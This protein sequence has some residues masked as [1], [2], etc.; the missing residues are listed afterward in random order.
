[1]KI[2]DEV[3]IDMNPESS[4]YGKHLSEES[5]DYEGDV[6]LAGGGK[7]DI[8]VKRGRGRFR[9]GLMALGRGGRFPGSIE[10]FGG[11]GMPGVY[12]SPQGKPTPWTQSP[13]TKKQ[14]EGT[15]SFDAYKGSSG[16]IGDVGGAVT[17]IVESIT[18][19]LFGFNLFPK[20][21]DSSQ[22]YAAEDAIDQDFG[23]Y[24]A[25]YI[26]K[27]VRTP[28][29]QFR[30]FGFSEGTGAFQSAADLGLPEELLS[31]APGTTMPGIDSPL[32][33][34][35]LIAKGNVPQLTSMQ[36]A[37][38][39]AI[40]DE[41]KEQI[42]LDEQLVDLKEAKNIALTEQ[43][44]LRTS[45][46]RGLATDAE[47]REAN[48]AA[49]GLYESGPAARRAMGE[50]YGDKVSLSDISGK[51]QEIEKGF[52]MQ[53]EGIE[54]EKSDVADVLTE[55]RRDFG[56]EV[57]QMLQGSTDQINTLLT[58]LKA[59]PEAH[60]A[61]GGLLASQ[62]DPISGEG[63]GQGGDIPAYGDLVGA[64]ASNLKTG[65]PT[66]GGMFT[67]EEIQLPTGST[68]SLYSQARADVDAANAF[69]N[70]MGS[71][72]FSDPFAFSTNIEGSED[73]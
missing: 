42:R 72:G 7:G 6:A 56:E 15:E 33:G 2:Y 17:D 54:G 69:A 59:I 36:S 3:T 30:G 25:D 52:Q 13:I 63:W 16:L 48:L 40:D 19:D 32:G 26:D 58:G 29:E 21:W 20:S 39:R 65:G 43:D 12:E 53:K 44:K 35:P 5:Y 70:W 28:L 57:G 67:P 4:T 14:Y 37:L 8:D 10:G 9:P 46:L 24:Y 61:Y 50:E 71:Q 49:T 38:G 68:G 41:A 1:M 27:G 23:D 64:R 45:T 55:S 34:G 60:A 31:Q 73:V 62:V 11:A 47:K 51:K 18:D 66:V 22:G